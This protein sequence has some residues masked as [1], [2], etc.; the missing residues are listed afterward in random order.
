MHYWGEKTASVKIY[1]AASGILL[2]IAHSC[3]KYY[4]ELQHNALVY[5]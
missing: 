4:E 1:Q 5:F 3:H 2:N